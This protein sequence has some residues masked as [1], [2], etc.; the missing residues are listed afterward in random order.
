[1]LVQVAADRLQKRQSIRSLC[2]SLVVL[3]Q[4]NAKHFTVALVLRQSYRLSFCVLEEP[5]LFFRL[6][7]EI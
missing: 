5:R 1:M 6:V 3:E 2:Q 4:H 7:I